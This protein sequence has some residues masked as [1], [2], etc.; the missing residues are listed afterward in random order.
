MGEPGGLLSMGLHRV[1]HNWR[2]LAAALCYA[3]SGQSCPTLCDPMNYSLPELFCPWDF[4][5]KNT[6]GVCHFLLHWKILTQLTNGLLKKYYPIQMANKHMKRCSTLLIIREMQI[7]TTMR[8]NLTPVGWPSSKCLQTINSG[9]CVEKREHS[10]TV[11]GNVNL[12][13]H[14]GRWYGDSLFFYFFNLNLF[15]GV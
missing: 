7:K 13:S 4:P 9:N 6:G 2:D 8:Y 1:G 12:Y 3:E 5:G 11:G 10:F 15:I 14:Y